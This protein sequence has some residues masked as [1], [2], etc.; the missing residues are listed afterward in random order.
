[1]KKIG[2]CDRA[3]KINIDQ[4]KKEIPNAEYEVKCLNMCS[5]CTEKAFAIVEGI[6]IITE[7]QETLIKLIKQEIAK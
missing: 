2:L 5:L 4:I 1:M 6:P 3:E 7:D